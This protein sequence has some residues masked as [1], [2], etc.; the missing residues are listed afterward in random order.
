V[1]ARVPFSLKRYPHTE[2]R[3]AFLR[4]VLDR[5]RAIPGVQSVSAAN[6]C[7]SRGSRRLAASVARTSLMLHPSLLPSKSLFPDTWV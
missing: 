4:D 3:W 7:H 6:H 2:Q 5:I 1:T